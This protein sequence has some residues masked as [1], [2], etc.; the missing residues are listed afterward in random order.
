MRAECRA[1]SVPSVASFRGGAQERRD[2]DDPADVGEAVFFSPDRVGAA[3]AY[4]PPW[5]W[6]DGVSGLGQGRELQN[7]REAGSRTAAESRSNRIN[8]RGK[9]PNEAALR[10]EKR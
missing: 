2:L 9:V 1:H 8:I 10:C 4:P 5:N 6:D 3:N 7:S